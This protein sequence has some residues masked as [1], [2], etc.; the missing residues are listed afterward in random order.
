MVHDQVYVP[1]CKELKAGSFGQD[2]PQ[3]GVSLF[4]PAFLTAL[5]WVTIINA[6]TLYS[7]YTGF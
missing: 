4:Q 7:G 5:H 6:G 2:H 1:L 3:H